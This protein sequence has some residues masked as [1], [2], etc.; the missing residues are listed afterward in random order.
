MSESILQN[1]ILVLTSIYPGSDVPNNFTPVVH[2]FTKEWVKLGY[3][4]RVIHYCTYFPSVYYKAPNWFRRII[5]NRLGIALPVKRL[6]CEKEY[7]YEG[8]RVYR[9]PLKKILPMGKYSV[10]ELKKACLGA[11][12]YLKKEGFNPS[13]V[14]SHWTNPQ[15]VVMAYLKSRFGAVT[16]MVL[17]GGVNR[18]LYKDIDGLVRAVDIWG[19]R[20]PKI[21]ESF[22]KEECCECECE[23][24]AFKTMFVM[25]IATSID[26]LAIGVSFAFLGVNIFAAAIVIGITTFLFSVAGIKIGNLFGSR[27]KSSAELFG[28]VVLVLMGLK[29]LME[30]LLG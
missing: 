1:K 16:T 13:Y 2:Y 30:H 9:I 17:H 27:Y 20:S 21:K 12:Y 8:V 6:D 26:A 3:D 4:V 14:I 29:I 25:A 7:E 5:Q 11:E 24:Y 22:E 15:L 18:K 10:K 19:Y 23:N 28:G